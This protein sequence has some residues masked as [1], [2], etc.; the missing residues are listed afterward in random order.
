M[1]FLICNNWSCSDLSWTA[2]DVKE[3]QTWS[4]VLIWHLNYLTGS[5]IV[6]G[7]FRAVLKNKHKCP[8]QT[9]ALLRP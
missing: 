4:P 6:S 8:R 7:G 3:E 2:F 5:T 1:P 9:A